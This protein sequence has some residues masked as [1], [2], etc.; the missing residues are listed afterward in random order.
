MKQAPQTQAPVAILRAE[1]EAWRTA[2]RMSREA[3]AIVIV[4]AHEASGADI[5]SEIAFDYGGDS[6]S[7]ARKS[8]QKIFRWLDEGNL[9]AN[10]FQS[11]LAALPRDAQIRCLGQMFAPMGIEVRAVGQPQAIGFDTLKH[12]R[13]VM[14]EGGE[15]QMALIGLRPDAT[16]AERLETHRELVEAEQAFGSAAAELMAEIT[17]AEALAQARAPGSK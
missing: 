13:S 6:F 5:A 14:K 10:M 3:V 9:P 16:H 17:A 4:E 15:G 11:V 7:R 2:S 1:I 12:L 8:A